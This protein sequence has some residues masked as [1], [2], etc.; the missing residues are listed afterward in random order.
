M[1][2]CSKYQLCDHGSPK[3][4]DCTQTF[5]FDIYRSCCTSP[6]RV[7]CSHRCPTTGQPTTTGTVRTKSTVQGDR[8][9]TS[10]ASTRPPAT[11]AGTWWLTHSTVARTVT[12]DTHG[13][14]E[15]RNTSNFV[16]YPSNNT[17]TGLPFTAEQSNP[18]ETSKGDFADETSTA[19]AGTSIGTE[20]YMC[21]PLL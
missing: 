2:D 12:K 20:T 16:T 17:T 18:T 8:I 6:D 7:D 10:N 9:V 11:S 15:V 4:R 3:E 14:T 1:T 21:A 13:T 5:V 19:S